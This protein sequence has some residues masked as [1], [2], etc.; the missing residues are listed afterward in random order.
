MI[1]DFCQQECG[2]VTMLNDTR[3]FECSRCRC[4]RVGIYDHHT[5]EQLID[6]LMVAHR[7][8]FSM[9]SVIKSLNGI[10]E[11]LRNGKFR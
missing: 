8:M 5:R 2:S 6:K 9:K 7:E 10:I 4:K 11:D 3:K 1:C